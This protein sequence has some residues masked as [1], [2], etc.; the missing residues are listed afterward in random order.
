MSFAGGMQSREK[1]PNSASN[2]PIWCLDPMQI[3][4]KKAQKN[5][6]KTSTEIKS[7][8]KF[9]GVDPTG[10]SDQIGKK[11]LGKIQLHFRFDEIFF[12]N[13]KSK[14]RKKNYNLW[15]FVELLT[16]CSGDFR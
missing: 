12:S 8:V 6:S 14:I 4:K 7:N 10:V 2:I 3:F 5:S 11:N 9:Y 15:L 1:R 16:P 13:T